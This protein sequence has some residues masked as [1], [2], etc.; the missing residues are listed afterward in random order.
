MPSSAELIRAAREAAGL[1]QSALAARVG[2]T[3]SA[4]ARLETGATE[5]SLARVDLIVTACGGRLHVALDKPA[6]TQAAAS[7]SPRRSPR[8][9]APVADPAVYQRRWD[10][11]ARMANFVLEGR[12]SVRTRR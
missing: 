6:G 8:P 9:S 11:L 2:T 7:R 12:W 4:I 3:Q 10:D 1:T 5:P